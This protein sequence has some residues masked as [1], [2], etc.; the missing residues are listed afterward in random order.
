[1][2][3]INPDLRDLQQKYEALNERLAKTEGE[4]QQLNRTASDTSRQTIWQ[5]VIFTITMAVTLIGVSSFQT[6]ALRREF[7]AQNEAVRQSLNE[8]KQDVR[9]IKQ[10]LRE[11]QTERRKPQK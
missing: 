8:L 2:S 11:M 4:V 3:A 1:M 6:D 9:E 10:E 5:F 7:N